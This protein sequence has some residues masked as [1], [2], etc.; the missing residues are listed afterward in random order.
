[1]NTH[2]CFVSSDSELPTAYVNVGSSLILFIIWNLLHSQ[3][4][5]K[6]QDNDSEHRELTVLMLV[7]TPGHWIFDMTSFLILSLNTNKPACLQLCETLRLCCSILNSDMNILLVFCLWFASCMNLHLV[8]AQTT[9]NRSYIQLLSQL[10][11]Q[12]F[13]SGPF[14]TQEKLYQ[15]PMIWGYPSISVSNWSTEVFIWTHWW[16]DRPF[17][18]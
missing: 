9:Q 10:Q 5:Q 12:L 1:M 6:E 7:E 8:Q 2:G 13:L 15:K 17:Y 11:P 16:R 3:I 4:F 14:S 18:F